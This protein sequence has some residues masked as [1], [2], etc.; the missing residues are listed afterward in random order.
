MA[1]TRTIAAATHG[2]YLIEAPASP[3]PAPLVVGFHGYAETAEAQ[4]DRLRAIP[5]SDGWCLVSVQALHLFYRGRSQ[6]VVAGWMTR[7]DRELAITDNI[8]YVKMVVEA[9]ARE[10]AMASTLVFAGF[11]QGV[12]MAF[13]AAAWSERPVAGVIACGGDVPPEL[14]AP[15]LA[16]VRTAIIGRGLADG[17]YTREKADVDAQRLRAAGVHLRRVEFDG[18]HEW[19][20]PFAA[21]AGA[22]LSECR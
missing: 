9:A 22:F 8:A 18:G 16:R 3:G 7:Q 1:N 10:S 20:A 19:S 12:A 5:G 15:A 6:E 14:E 4:L 11:S 13:R 2:R 17:F 21:A